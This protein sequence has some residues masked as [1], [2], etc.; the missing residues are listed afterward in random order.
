MNSTR[1]IVLVGP[2]HRLIL[3]AVSGQGIDQRADRQRI[4]V[5][6]DARWAAGAFACDW[7]IS[8]VASCKALDSTSSGSI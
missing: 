7:A 8:S 3:G 6:Q 4:G 2:A 1:H 5:G